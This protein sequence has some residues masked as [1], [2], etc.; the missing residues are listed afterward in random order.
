M[1]KLPHSIDL[2]M[3]PSFIHDVSFMPNETAIVFCSGRRRI[4][5]HPSVF[6][7]MALREI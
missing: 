1:L 4:D 2:C 3:K 6:P 7:V 5:V